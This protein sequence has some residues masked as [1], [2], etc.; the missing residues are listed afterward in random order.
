[1]KPGGG[2]EPSGALAKAINKDF[3]SFNKFREELMNAA[4]T[5]FGSG[6]AWLGYD[7]KKQ[8]LV[9]TKTTGE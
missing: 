9:V 4:L 5:A 3:G 6:W 7:M 8:K 2:G 1:M